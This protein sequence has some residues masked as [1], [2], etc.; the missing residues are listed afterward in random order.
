MKQPKS[1]L[2]T[3]GDATL[4]VRNKAETQAIEVKKGGRAGWQ[5]AGAAPQS[6]GERFLFEEKLKYDEGSKTFEA[7]KSIEL[8]IKQVRSMCG[9]TLMIGLT[10]H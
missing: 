5:G 9:H 7:G 8:V 1:A 6:E 3:A 10:D 4:P 2:S